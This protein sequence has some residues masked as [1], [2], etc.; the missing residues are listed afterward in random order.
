[1]THA[2]CLHPI[3][4]YYKGG[5]R[6]ACSY[7]H[8]LSLVIWLI[9]ILS[10]IHFW[11]DSLNVGRGSTRGRGSHQKRNLFYILIFF[12][13]NECMQDFKIR[14]KGGGDPKSDFMDATLPQWWDN[15]G[16][17]HGRKRLL[18]TSGRNSSFA[19][20]K[21]SFQCKIRTCE[22]LGGNKGCENLGGNEGCENLDEN[23]GMKK[24]KEDQGYEK[25]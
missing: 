19:C 3:S 20:S 21:P 23:K 9:L 10:I 7:L 8:Y 1:M 25:F 13:K 4:K 17:G 5:K 2:Y 16:K 14:N 24:F 15:S 11:E 22:Y 12:E 6:T 18:G